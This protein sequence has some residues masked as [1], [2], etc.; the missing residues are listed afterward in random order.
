MEVSNT[1]KA[2][3]VS[4]QLDL[5]WST[6]PDATDPWSD[7][8]TLPYGRH[9]AVGQ[10]LL[11]TITGRANLME[12][13][14]RVKANG[15]AAGIDGMSV[16]AFP[17]FWQTHGDRIVAQLKEGTYR[18]AAVRRVWIPKGNGEQ[19]PL[20]VPTVLDRVI[21]QAI[22]QE[23]SFLYEAQF[24]EHSYGF[25][26]GRRAHDA[27]K[28]IRQAAQDGCV[29]AV[30]CDLKS[31][32]DKVDHREL[33][34]RLRRR[35]EDNRVLC[36]IGRYLRAGVRLPDGSNEATP[37]GVPQGGPLSPLLANIMLDDLDHELERRGHRFARYADDFI[38]VV[39][40]KRAAE[41][42]LRSIGGYIETKLKL[43]VNEAKTKA[44]RLSQ[45][46]FLG[47][48]ITPKRIRCLDAKIRTFK[49]TI[50]QITCRSWG[51][52]MEERL[53]RL[54]LYVNGWLGYYAIGVPYKD[55]RYLDQWLRRRVRLC[56]WKQWRIPRTRFRNL[57]KL[58]INRSAIKQASRCRK[59]YWRCSRLRVVGIAM[60][61]Q[62]LAE[63]GCPSIKEQW[64]K[65]CYPNG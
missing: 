48:V 31:F 17:K 11:E 18:P 10:K 63:Q 16:E 30:D 26:P 19:R 56:Y 62:W 12:A 34:R 1:M 47:F 44:A 59:G 40:S 28:S 54:R 51:I 33:M 4:G 46:S 5:R 41:R 24:S 57:L 32:F 50:R 49:Q 25:R 29:Y 45:C 8:N 55:I 58:G 53:E 21:Q 64:L 20:G 13:W 61:N 3:T 27:V 60:N 42:V 39:K 35:I 7:V 9:G 36:L 2:R 38:I 23:L 15:G 14:R 43:V 22:A 52:S 6:H 37:E 65:L